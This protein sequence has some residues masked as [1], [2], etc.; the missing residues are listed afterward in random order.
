MAEYGHS[1]FPGFPGYWGDVAVQLEHVDPTFIVYS[2]SDG[3]FTR[4]DGA[5]IQFVPDGL[6]G[7]IL[8]GTIN[9]I[10]R[11]A[12]LNDASGDEFVINFNYSATTLAS[13]PNGSPFSSILADIFAGDD[14]VNGNAGNDTLKGFAGNDTIVGAGGADFLDGGTGDD[15]LRGG[16]GNDTYVIDSAHDTVDETG[17]D[18]IDTVRSTVSQSLLNFFFGENILGD[19][20]NLVLLG[21][22][23]TG[24]GNN[25]D[26][27]ITGNALNNPLEGFGGNDTLIGGDGNDSLSGGMGLRCPSRW[28]GQRLVRAGGPPVRPH[29]QRWPATF[30]VPGELGSPPVSGGDEAKAQ[31]HHR[32]RCSWLRSAWLLSPR[33][34]RLGRMSD[35]FSDLAGPPG[36]LGSNGH[37]RW[38]LPA[39]IYLAP[40]GA[41]NS[42]RV[43]A[44]SGTDPGATAR[45]FDRGQRR[46]PPCLELIRP[47]KRFK[48]RLGSSDRRFQGRWG[49]SANDCVRS[50]WW[51]RAST[52]SGDGRVACWRMSRAPSKRMAVA[53]H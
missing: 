3:S 22:A 12:A 52:S 20:E 45:R 37:W 34:V 36:A 46:L 27:V 24:I 7:Q 44:R 8:V 5:G 14:L 19:V 28:R 39:W 26:N 11:T 4:F 31:S 10:T 53:W 49:R 1:V 25:L 48:A 51:I 47:C 2:N 35:L 29:S 30:V 17:G 33:R 43:D 50:I 38:P 23:A 6:G 18:G 13:H 40:F 15:I 41:T 21:G 16:L 32:L 42:G 9:S